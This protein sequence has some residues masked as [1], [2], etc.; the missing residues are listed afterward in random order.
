MEILVFGAGAMGSF[1]GGLLS[2]RHE[3]LLIG[4]AEHVDA[5]RASGLR[6][7]GKT[8]LIAKPKAATSVPLN[9]RP[10]LVLVTT[11]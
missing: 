8:S 10:D 4:R 2:R 1:F 7:S 11:K 3:V 9:A 5:V 6:I